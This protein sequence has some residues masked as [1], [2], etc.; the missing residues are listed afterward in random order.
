MQ[1]FGLMTFSHFSL[2][3]IKASCLLRLVR[4]IGGREITW[5]PPLLSFTA[6]HLLLLPEEMITF[7][8]NIDFVKSNRSTFYYLLLK[9][10]LG[11]TLRIMCKLY[12]DYS[13]SSGKAWY[14]WEGLQ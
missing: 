14:I 1:F 6:E 2:L 9:I 12:H 4:F 7:R 3:T 13:I 11:Q 8:N 10:D 5:P